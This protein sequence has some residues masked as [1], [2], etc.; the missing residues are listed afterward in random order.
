MAR[1]LPPRA[2]ERPLISL[3]EAA[4]LAGQ[5][6]SWAYEHRDSLPGVVV[7]GGRY[8]VRRAPFVRWFEGE[9]VPAAP[10]RLRAVG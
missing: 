6:R 10:A 4:D 3:T 2:A 5:S 8:Y 7:I 1:E 9:D